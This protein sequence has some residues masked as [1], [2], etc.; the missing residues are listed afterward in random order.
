[1]LHEKSSSCP[2]GLIISVSFQHKTRKS[3]QTQKKR[4]ENVKHKWDSGSSV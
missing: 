3:K 1:M 2:K 4:G